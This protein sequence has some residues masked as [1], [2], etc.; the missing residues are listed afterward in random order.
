MKLVK[1]Y[2][3]K[4]L[5]MEDMFGGI[6]AV[7]LLLFMLFCFKDGISG[8]DF[9]WHVK[10]G[11]WIADNGEVPETGV[12]SWIAME[13]DIPWT[14]QEWL[15]EVIFY[16]IYDALGEAGIFCFSVILLIFIL[17]SLYCKF[18]SYFKENIVIGV[19]FYIF[20]VK[21][22]SMFFYGRPHVF[23]FVLMYL[24]LD[25]IYSFSKNNNTKK[26]YSLPVIAIL[27]SNF[28]GGSSNLL[29][30]ICIV[31]ILCHIK[32]WRFGRVYSEK[33][34][35]KYIY[36]LGGVTLLSFL[37]M[38]INPNTYKIIIYPYVNMADDFMLKVISE[39]RTPDPKIM[40]ELILYFGPVF[41]MT[42]GIFI[43]K[44]KVQLFDVMIMLISL[45]LFFRSVRFVML[46]LIFAPFYAFR[47]VP[48]CRIKETTPKGKCLFS[49][50]IIP[51]L[52]SIGMCVSTIIISAKDNDLITKSLDQKIID[53]V[54][55][56]APSRIYN[57]YNYGELLIYNDINVFV[58]GRADIYAYDNILKDAISISDLKNYNDA[59]N[60]MFDIERTLTKYNFD[61]FL[62][63]CN[64]PIYYYLSTNSDKYKLL[65]E[66]KQTAY[67]KVIS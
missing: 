49:L 24:T 52:I 56:D 23:S 32:N 27:W 7:A 36:K 29:Y 22:S 44:E 66:N 55:A 57:D 48:R 3:L 11:E 18:Y 28:H 30:I 64:K 15:S 33:Y 58:D 21:I 38:F 63:S 67:F 13:Q 47:Y 62:I 59:P 8:N 1:K 51:I 25:C 65:Y 12:F 5:K 34:D 53:I 19:L 40:G 61:A 54:R 10:I 26:I 39:W 60:E 16:H 2:N 20:F 35:N 17:F 45:L 46:W 6:F 37:V 14:S 4:N 9:W 43:Y 31:F 50:L 41:I 42:I